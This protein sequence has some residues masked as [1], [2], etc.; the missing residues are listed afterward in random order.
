MATCATVE[1]KAG[2]KTGT[3]RAGLRTGDGIDFQEPA[4]PLVE[5][6]NFGLT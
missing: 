5:V 3:W 4:Q 2:A 1:V 6:S